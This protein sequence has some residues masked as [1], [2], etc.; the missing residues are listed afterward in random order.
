MSEDT[1]KF[2]KTTILL[3]LSASEEQIRSLTGNVITE[4]IQVS[5]LLTWPGILEKLITIV[6]GV[7][8]TVQDSP[9]VRESAMGALAKVCEDNRQ[10]LDRDYNGQRPLDFMIPKLLSFTASPIAKVRSNALASINFFIPNKSQAVMS[11]LDNM[12]KAIFTLATDTSEDVRRNVCRAIVSIVD[13]QPEAIKPHM[14]GIVN[15][16]ISQQKKTEDGE[17]S[18]VASEAA[19]FWLT[20]GEHDVQNVL[21]EP[22][23]GKIVPTLLES[24]VYS[25]E[26]MERLGGEGDD[27]DEE[28]KKEDIKPVFAK[29]KPRMPNGAE[30]SDANGSSKEEGELSDEEAELEDELGSEDP[31]D[32]WNLRKCSAAALDVIA[33]AFGQTVFHIILPYL[34]QSLFHAEWQYREAA[35]LALGAVASGCMDGVTPHLP[36]LVPYLIGLL[37]DPEPLVRQITCWTLGRYSAWAA[38]LEDPQLSN[39]Y[40]EPMMEGL[41]K[42]MLDKNKRVQAA[43]A[44]AFA[45][46]EE[47]SKDRLIPYT[48]PIVQQFIM[49]MGVY[50]DRNMYIL[51]DSIQTLAE[52]V[53]SEL[54]K[55]E[56]VDIL[57]PAL[58][59]RWKLVKDENRELFPLLEVS[60]S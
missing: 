33:S 57:M 45:N 20:L 2:I 41:L 54:A 28:D 12:L 11:N 21:L 5:G 52:H 29:S 59:G 9:G 43:G 17:E 7:D 15:Y 14:D 55:K 4:I 53:G 19:E 24:M 18:E 10:S 26:D 44:S 47:Q 51:Y 16:M 48:L 13:V 35:V 1:Q 8:P 50:K 60:D 6:E 23:L 58:I 3:G 42:K 34:K 49:A 39:E 32:K 25:E 36:E 27:M 46:L 31:E 40:F 37:N 38:E 30:T 22:Y 56:V